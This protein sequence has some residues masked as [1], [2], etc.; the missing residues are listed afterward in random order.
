MKKIHSLVLLPVVAIVLS[1]CSS[2][3]S[4]ADVNK[5]TAD[6]L[7]NSFQARGIATL[8][9]LDQDQANA[10]CLQADV[11]IQTG[12]RIGVHNGFK[13]QPF[14][15]SLFSHLNVIVQVLQASVSAS[16]IHTAG[17]RCG[18]Q[19]MA[20]GCSRNRHLQVIA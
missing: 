12:L 17:T 14:H 15:R 13:R 4:P 20:L 5:A 6:M 3:P 7:K 8:D 1:A 9:R 11:S 2:A 10:A 19:H 18:H 16:P